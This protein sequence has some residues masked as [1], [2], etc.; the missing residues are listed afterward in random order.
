[1]RLSQPIE[2]AAYFWLPDSPENK[3]PGTLHISLL[4]EA[5]AEVI[6][7]FSVNNELFSNLDR[8]IGITEDGESFTLSECYC[9][10][11]ILR[12]GGLSRFSIHAKHALIG[13]SYVEGIPI[14]FTTF[15]FSV[16]GLD[17]WLGITGI[18]VAHDW[19][20]QIASI[21]YVI[22]DGMTISLPNEFTLSFIFTWTNPGFPIIKEAKIT[23]KAY[24]EL[25]CESPRSLQDFFDLVF[26]INNFMRFVMD[27]TVA[28]DYAEGYSPDIV[29]TL[30]NGDRYEA[31]VKIYFY[32][33]NLPIEK[34]IIYPNDMLLPFFIMPVNIESAMNYWLNNYAKFEPAFNLY[35]SAK[36]SESM[37][38]EGKFLFLI[39]GLETMHR[40]SSQ[41]TYMP[42]NEFQ[43]LVAL[44]LVTCPDKNKKW[45]EGKLEYANELS[46]RTRMRKMI[47]PF[48]SLFGDNKQQKDF[49][50][51]TVSTRNYLTHYSPETSVVA[52]RDVKLISLCRKLEGLFQLHLLKVIGFDQSDMKKI[53]NNNVAVRSKLGIVPEEIFDGISE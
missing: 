51:L 7:I 25:K 43:K 52:A 37:Y 6:G 35:F 36:A 34:P 2:K 26:K 42:E 49:I 24:I 39:Q 4:G 13:F 1:M 28:I 15:R 38:L 31:S 21:S 47:E 40:R 23:Q 53:I 29:R 41:D 30:D 27:K 32:S 18:K 45:L 50:A 14:T 3:F 44:L 46:L 9:W 11:K 48:S 12:F 33:T 10:P 5:T 16:E 22:P 19:Q 20:E 17:E 8:I